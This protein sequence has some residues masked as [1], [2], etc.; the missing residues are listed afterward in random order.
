[1]ETGNK[2]HLNGYPHITGTIITTIDGKMGKIYQVKWDDG[3]T[4]RNFEPTLCQCT[5]RKC[6]EIKE[7]K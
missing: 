7:G 4:T 5:D 3:K 2:I 6:E 1:M